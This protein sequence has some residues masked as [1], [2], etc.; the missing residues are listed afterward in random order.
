[1]CQTRVV[2]GAAR[3]AHDTRCAIDVAA[4]GR[5]CPAPSA[6]GSA[7]V[8]LSV[9]LQ[10]SLIQI[11]F[12][13]RVDA[14]M[15]PSPSDRAEEHHKADR[16]DKAAPAGNEPERHNAADRWRR[17]R[18]IRVFGLLK[19]LS[20]GTA[21]VPL[22]RGSRCRHEPCF[23]FGDLRMNRTLAPDNDTGMNDQ[24]PP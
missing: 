6:R 18:S 16:F 13:L 22:G 2:Q 24:P 7:R 8:A 19:S 21:I 3:A 4:P 14:I 23:R 15:A 11:K 10:P 17:P 20:F 9:K 5:S 1:M 12:D